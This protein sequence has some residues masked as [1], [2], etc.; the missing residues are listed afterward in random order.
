MVNYMYPI[1]NPPQKIQT[2]RLEFV[3]C[4]SKVGGIFGRSFCG[5]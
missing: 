3:T 2:V 5:F 4:E 1:S